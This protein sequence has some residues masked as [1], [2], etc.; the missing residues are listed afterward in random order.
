MSDSTRQQIT[1]CL[2]D[3]VET[4][5][6]PRI[7]SESFREFE[8][9]PQIIQR[10][11]QFDNGTYNRVEIAS[12]DAWV[13]LALFW[14]D[15]Q[16]SIHD[17]DQSE[18]GFRIIAGEIEETRYTELSTGKV[19]EVARRVLTPGM[20]VSSHY[21]A[22]HRL[23]THPGQQAITLH[24]YSPRLDFHDMNVFELAD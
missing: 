21:D 17:H 13:L 14:E 23:A 1:R 24:A 4:G 22:I 2:G 5:A 11:G 20:Q 3:C 19:R 12:C 15:T 16:T 18:C 6:D 10:C 9:D 8:F 7:V